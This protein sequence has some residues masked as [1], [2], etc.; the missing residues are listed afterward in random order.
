ML[1]ITR[2]ESLT[3]SVAIGKDSTTQLIVASK[4]SAINIL[5]IKKNKAIE[6]VDSISNKID[7]IIVVDTDSTRFIKVE[8]AIFK[9]LV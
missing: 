3:K 1:K 5:L 4:S 6:R 9:N 2:S 7:D 8:S